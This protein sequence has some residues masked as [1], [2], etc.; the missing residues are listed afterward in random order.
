M[1][2][3][4]DQPQLP[5]IISPTILLKSTHYALIGKKHIICYI[6][7]KE[8]CLRKYY[9]PTR[10]VKR[11]KRRPS[12]ELRL[13]FPMYEKDIM[14]IGK[15]ELILTNV[16]GESLTFPIVAIESII[17]NATGEILWA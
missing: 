6:I 17:D 16:I 14:S 15:D 8:S 2:R 12:N 5:K 13:Y 10:F 7:D 3:Q 1:P 9:F 11:V 4:R